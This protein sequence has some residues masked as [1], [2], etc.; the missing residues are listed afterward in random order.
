MQKVFGVLEKYIK[1]GDTVPTQENQKLNSKYK[2]Y[3]KIVKTLAQVINLLRKQRL[4]CRRHRQDKKAM[5]DHEKP[6]NFLAAFH[7]I[8]EYNPTYDITD[9]MD[10][11]TPKDVTYFNPRS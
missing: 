10:V 2:I 5:D 7:K 9:H 4:A 8:A 3:T 6:G 11:P 1:P